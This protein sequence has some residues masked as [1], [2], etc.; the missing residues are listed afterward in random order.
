VSP[1]EDEELPRRD[2]WR[3]VRKTVAQTVVVFTI[4]FVFAL[5]RAAFGLT[6]FKVDRSPAAWTVWGIGIAVMI[7]ASVLA[8][9]L[10]RGKA[11]AALGNRSAWLAGGLWLVGLVFVFV[12][13][14]MVP[15]PTL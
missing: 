9:Q 3:A 5:G 7:T 6:K 13:S 4:P 15:A 12:Y 11:P 8:I 2:N 14:Q 1:D 10:L